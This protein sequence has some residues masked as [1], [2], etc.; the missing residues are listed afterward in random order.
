MDQAKEREQ[1]IL[2]QDKANL[3]GMRH[4]ETEKIKEILKKRN[5]TFYDIPSDGNW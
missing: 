4:L 1:M 2:E 3:L 5:L